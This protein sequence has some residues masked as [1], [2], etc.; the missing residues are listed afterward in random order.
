MAGNKFQL[1]RTS[2]SGREANTDTIDIGE[3]ALNITDG[4]MY[5]T[6]G[7]VVFEIGAN[8][9]SQ[10]ISTNNFNV[11]NTLYVVSN[12]N[13]GVGNTNPSHELRIEG[14]ISLTGGIHA[15]GSLGTS[16]Q[17]LTSNGSGVY[18]ADAGTS[19]GKAIAMAIVFS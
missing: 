4:I 2:V 9:T 5:S 16:E 14:D 7:S 3:L 11:G 8:L 6:N 15:N 10:Y 13:I 18:W 19:S 17:V 12:G 1:K